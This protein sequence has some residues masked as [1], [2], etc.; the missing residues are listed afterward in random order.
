MSARSRSALQPSQCKK[1]SFNPSLAIAALLCALDARI[2]VSNK[3]RLW[4]VILSPAN[5]TARAAPTLL[6][7]SACSRAPQWFLFLE[8]G[9]AS[10]SASCDV[11][12]PRLDIAKSRYW[13]AS[14]EGPKRRNEEIVVHNTGPSASRRDD[15]TTGIFAFEWPSNRP[16]L[17]FWKAPTEATVS[18]PLSPLTAPA[19]THPVPQGAQPLPR[20]RPS[21][22]MQKA[23]L[24]GKVPKEPAVKPSAAPAA[25]SV[26]PVAPRR[27][28]T[29]PKG[30][31]QIATPD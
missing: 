16:G 25:A 8:I 30:V 21:N 14:A 18:I 20:P 1:V 19:N 17:L 2:R 23:K 5:A 10:R 6:W 4:A 11:G 12:A 9:A 24:P 29:T 15:R 7:T 22:L 3:H 27:A 31:P 13:T 26:A 28:P